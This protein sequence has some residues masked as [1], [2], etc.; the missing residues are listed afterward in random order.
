MTDT[1]NMADTIDVR[2]LIERFDELD[3]DHDGDNAPAGE[4]ESLRR[5]LDELRGNGGDAQ[6]DHGRW[7][8]GT[9]IRES[10][11]K[12]YAQELADDI[13][14]VNHDAQWPYTCIDW[15]RAA[16][17]LRQDYTS[18]DYDGITYWYR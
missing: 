7:Y 4:Y 9:L 2:D 5:L 18:V 10:Y 1:S 8:P 16:D 17:E 12:D 15:D 13:G 6:D 11:W 14:A 3:A